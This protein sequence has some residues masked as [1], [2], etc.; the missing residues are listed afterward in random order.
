MDIAVLL[1][2]I[3]SLTDM[4]ECTVFQAVRVIYMGTNFSGCIIFY[5][6]YWNVSKSIRCV[7]KV[8]SKYFEVYKCN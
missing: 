6:N 4:T 3:K 7:C 5:K 1:T 8:I 2:Y